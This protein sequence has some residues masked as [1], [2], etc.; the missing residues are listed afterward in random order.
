MRNPT[1][2]AVVALAYLLII[3]IASSVHAQN[4]PL[5]HPPRPKVVGP[6]KWTPLAQ[7][8]SATYWTLEPGWNAGD[9]Q[10][11]EPP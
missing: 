8:V 7:E 3:F 1:F 9:A 10:Q 11:R 5:A 4:G 2:R 6:A